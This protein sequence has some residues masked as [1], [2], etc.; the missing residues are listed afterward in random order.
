LAWANNS[1]SI[2]MV[3]K[4]QDRQLRL[5]LQTG[6]EG[7]NGTI[8]AGVSFKP[9]CRN[10]CAG[11]IWISQHVVQHNQRASGSSKPLNLKHSS[12]TNLGNILHLLFIF[13]PSGIQHCLSSREIM[14]VGKTGGESVENQFAVF[15]GAIWDIGEFKKTRRLFF[16]VFVDHFA[17]DIALREFCFV[18]SVEV[19]V[20]GG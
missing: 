2:S 8:L 12:H 5:Q 6:E 14:A 16:V 17:F 19:V 13:N 18:L 20:R 1:I 15:H 11:R 3:R 9:H 7:N 10:S 4:E